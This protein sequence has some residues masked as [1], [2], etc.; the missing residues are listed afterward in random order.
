MFACT[1]AGAPPQ[2]GALAGPGGRAP[3]ERARLPGARTGRARQLLHLQ[4][5]R[6]RP[7]PAPRL[8]RGLSPQR[9]RA[10]PGTDQPRWCAATPSPSNALP[11]CSVDVLT[12]LPAALCACASPRDDCCE[13]RAPWQA[14]AC[15]RVDYA[16][17]RSGQGATRWQTSAGYL[18]PEIAEMRGAIREEVDE[19]REEGGADAAERGESPPPPEGNPGGHRQRRSTASIELLEPGARPKKA[20]WIRRSFAFCRK[21]CGVVCS[22][23]S[24]AACVRLCPPFSLLIFLSSYRIVLSGLRARTWSRR[25][26]QE[27]LEDQEQKF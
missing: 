10:R 12:I 22:V 19:E 13:T 11:S 25:V 15:N 5:P 26:P 4:L 18:P 3:D 20:G 16:N 14:A 24:Q 23:V 9:R 6:P 1:A 27:S 7:R 8:R 2:G 21:H 17:T